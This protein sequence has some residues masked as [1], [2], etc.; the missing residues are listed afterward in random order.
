MDKLTHFWF[1]KNFVYGLF[2]TC[3][4]KLQYTINRLINLQDKPYVFIC[5]LIKKKSL[6]CDAALLIPIWKRFEG[7][8][9]KRRIPFVAA[10]LYMFVQH[11]CFLYLGV[12]DVKNKPR[13][14][15]VYDIKFSC[16]RL[17]A[18]SSSYM[19]WL[20]SQTR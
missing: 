17:L 20:K 14:D 9:N 11:C 15:N 7:L 19:K 4:C 10:M 5:G 13:Q 3:V 1:F 12:L 2:Y 18:F 8:K 16:I 6:D